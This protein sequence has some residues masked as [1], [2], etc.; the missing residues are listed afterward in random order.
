MNR[1]IIRI[2]ILA[3][4]TAMNAMA[5]N[6]ETSFAQ[7]PDGPY[8]TDITAAVKPGVNTLEVEVV[9]TWLNRLIGDE[10]SA[11]TQR[12]TSVTLKNGWSATTAL[13]PAGLLGPVNLRFSEE[14]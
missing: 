3:L 12:V 14:K 8:V 10:Q 4:V 9:N 7:P 1:T 6:L 5:A 11:E 2:A 13:L